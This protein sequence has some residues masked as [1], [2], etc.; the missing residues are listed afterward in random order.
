ML[1]R[2]KCSS[3]VQSLAGLAIICAFAS[4]KREPNPV[5]QPAASSP[6]SVAPAA[7]GGAPQQVAAQSTGGSPSST[8]GA[9]SAPIVN[10]NALSLDNIS[11]FTAK[12][13]AY[14]TIPY[15]GKLYDAQNQFDKATY[16]F[17]ATKANYY[18]VCASLASLSKDFD[19]SL[20]VNGT[21]ESAFAQ[22]QR[23]GAQGCRTIKLKANDFSEVR[24]QQASGTPVEFAPNDSWDWMN[25]QAVLGSVSLDSIEAFSAKP[26]TFTKVPYASKR[27]D[28]GNQFD[29]K[30][31]RFSA[32]EAGDYRVCAALATSPVIFEIDIFVNDKRTNALGYSHNGFASGCRTVRLSKGQY[33][34]VWTYPATSAPQKFE[35]KKF[36]NWMTVDKVSATSAPSDVYLDN[37]ASF[38]APQNTPTKVPYSRKV[39]DDRNQ[40]DIRSSRFTAAE[41]NDYR[42]CA[43]LTSLAEDFDL[44]LTVNGIRDKGIAMSTK[45]FARGCRTVRLKNAGDYIEVQFQQ[46][47]VASLSLPENFFWDWL[48]IEPLDVL[49]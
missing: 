43:S 49:K 23:G 18:H 5:P 35:P 3:S 20:F 27:Y 15:I 44:S 9:S 2:N 47:S 34:E 16:R 25:I 32:A 4:C 40:F 17:K 45:G 12:P 24:V 28:V 22:A 10:K 31:K 48:T 26:N 1:V 11:A 39:Y 19:L 29:V 30:S 46:S 21:R 14:V 42:V 36:W 13:G 37:A 41:P 38:A 7:V 8:G 33:V 6:G